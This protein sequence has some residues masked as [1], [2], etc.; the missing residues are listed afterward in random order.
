MEQLVLH[1]LNV[2]KTLGDVLQENNITFNK[3]EKYWVI[4][5]TE[6]IGSGNF[7]KI[8]DIG[9]NKVLKISKDVN[10]YNAIKYFQNFIQTVHESDL[11]FIHTIQLPEIVCP[12]NEDFYEHFNDGSYGDDKKHIRYY[13]IYPKLYAL[14]EEENNFFEDIIY[15]L[16][17]ASGFDEIEMDTDIDYYSDLQDEFES[18]Y[19]SLNKD[20]IFSFVRNVIELNYEHV[21]SDMHIGNIMRNKFG[22]YKLIDFQ[23]EI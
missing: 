20:A 23:K 13:Y 7:A 11:W 9:N 12:V 8:F 5:N 1:N 22:D 4:A 21:I 14:T 6:L 15:F 2:N 16:G 3:F 19:E 18:K 10:E 17:G